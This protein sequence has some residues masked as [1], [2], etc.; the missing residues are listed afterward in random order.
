MDS[1]KHVLEKGLSGEEAHGGDRSETSTPTQMSEE[2]MIT[3]PE[4]FHVKL[5]SPFR[6]LSKGG[7]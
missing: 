7:M 5:K 2:M 3:Y 1:I 4:S 6:Y